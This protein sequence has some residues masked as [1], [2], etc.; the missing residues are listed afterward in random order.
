MNFAWARLHL[1][2]I[3][4]LQTL[5]K[6]PA[7]EVKKILEYAEYHGIEYFDSTMLWQFRIFIGTILAQICQSIN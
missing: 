1:G 5:E 7:Q 6:S 4:E 3:M 2:L